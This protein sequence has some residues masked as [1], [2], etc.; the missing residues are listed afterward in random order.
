MYKY[1]EIEDI[2]MKNSFLLDVMVLTGC[3]SSSEEKAK[4]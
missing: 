4:E 3:S 1:I 2:K